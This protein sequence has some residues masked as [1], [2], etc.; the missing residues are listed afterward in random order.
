M[1]GGV[2]WQLVAGAVAALVGLFLLLTQAVRYRLS[3]HEFEVLLGNVV[4]RRIALG[5]IDAVYVGSRFPAE[6]WP[7]RS[8]LRGGRLTIRRKR[9]FPRHLTITPPDPEQLRKNLCYTLG[10]KP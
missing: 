9:G 5:N 1:S 4:I 3:R 10:W 6:F 7:S 8:F 2:P